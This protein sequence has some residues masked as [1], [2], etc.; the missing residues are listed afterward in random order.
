MYLGNGWGWLVVSLEE[1]EV[2]SLPLSPLGP[3][4]SSLSVPLARDGSGLPS[5]HA[6]FLSLQYPPPSS[7]H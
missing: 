3:G 6:A 5:M 1:G 4:T 2:P 7:A